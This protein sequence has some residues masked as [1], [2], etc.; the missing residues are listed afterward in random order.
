M[1]DKNDATKC[2]CQRV[3]VSSHDELVEM[4]AKIQTVLWPEGHPE[5]SEPVENWSAETV[6]QV[7][8]IFDEAGLSPHSSF[9]C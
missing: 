9:G 6:R 5:G 1:Y 2:M 7:A 4:V 8:L 3:H